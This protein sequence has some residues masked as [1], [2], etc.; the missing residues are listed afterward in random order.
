MSFKVSWKLHSLSAVTSVFICLLFK[1][2]LIIAITEIMLAI[3]F[4]KI[5][6]NYVVSYLVLV[7]GSLFLTTFVHE[8]LHGLMYI[9]FG[10]KVK[11]GLKLI[12]AYT[13]ETSGIIL[14]RT[15]FLI[16]LLAPLTIISLLSL[17]LGSG[18]GGLIFI[19]NLLGSTGDLMMAFYLCKGNERSYI[20]D[21]DY[22]FDVI[23]NNKN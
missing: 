4:I 13:V 21:R 5:G 6:E 8:I 14:H 2:S 7:G 12:C 10:G 17:F 9:L 3:A 15:K 11:F 20:I 19:F 23:E 1:E 16:V 18:F 22:G